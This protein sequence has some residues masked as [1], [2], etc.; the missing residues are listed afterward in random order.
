MDGTIGA[1]SSLAVEFLIYERFILTSTFDAGLL[2]DPFLNH[3]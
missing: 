3:E 2:M 1:L